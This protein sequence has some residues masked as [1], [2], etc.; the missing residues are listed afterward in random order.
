MPV[1]PIVLLAFIPAALALNLTPGADMMFCLGQGLRNGP[2][3]AMAANLGIGIGGLI[4][5]IIAG[6]GLGAAIA[7]VPWMFDVIRW[8]GVAYLLAGLGRFAGRTSR[9]RPGA[10]YRKCVSR[11]A[12]REPDEP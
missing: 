10:G 5:A 6:L 11:C 12:D 3:A 8:V 9:A 1:D 2:R 4:Q 7:A